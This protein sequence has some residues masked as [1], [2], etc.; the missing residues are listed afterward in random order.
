M[1]MVVVM[2]VEFI[3]NLDSVEIDMD[4]V[5]WAENLRGWS[6]MRP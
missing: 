4:E 3:R 2:G 6:G 5:E 1:S